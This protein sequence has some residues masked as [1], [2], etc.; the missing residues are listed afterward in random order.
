[1]S[2]SRGSQ[3]EFPG[4]WFRARSGG[5]SCDCVLSR[6]HFSSVRRVHFVTRCCPGAISILEHVRVKCPGVVLMK[7]GRVQGDISANPRVHA[8]H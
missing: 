6:G 7:V 1:M 4:G 3:A 5:Y 8:W 2:T